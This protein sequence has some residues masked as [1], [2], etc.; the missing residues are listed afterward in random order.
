[1]SKFDHDQP[2]I[3]PKGTLML[4]RHWNLLCDVEDRFVF[5]VDVVAMLA[6]GRK[7]ETVIAT[8]SV[9]DIDTLVLLAEAVI[10]ILSNG[11]GDLP[12]NAKEWKIARQICPICEDRGHAEDDC[13]DY[14][15]AWN[16]DL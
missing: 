16:I 1:M 5:L 8:L 11:K 6:P 3:K 13:P 2:I 14:D 12:A 10:G 9:E 7:P 4:D 15:E